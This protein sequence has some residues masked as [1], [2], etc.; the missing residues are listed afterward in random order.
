[1][2]K[3]EWAGNATHSPASDNMTLSQVS[4]SNQYIFTVESNSS[5]SGLS[6]DEFNQSIRF[7]VEGPNGTKGYA[8]VTVPKSL[9][10]A[11][12]N[13]M[14]YVDDLET[15][16]ETSSRGNTW[17]LA[18]EYPHSEHR[19]VVDLD[20][21]PVPEYG[22]LLMIMPLLMVMLLLAVIASRKTLARKGKA[23]TLPLRLH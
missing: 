20:F 1:M 19:V 4:F 21:T 6:Y 3:A 15:S 8:Q 18:I 14:V 17:V 12:A 2:L 10:L 9:A 13:M 7:S 22:E 5:T 16:F 23:A 11:P